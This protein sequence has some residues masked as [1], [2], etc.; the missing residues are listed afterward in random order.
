MSDGYKLQPST[1]NGKKGS[2]AAR[3]QD[4]F[5]NRGN[6]STP[7]SASCKKL[8]RFSPRVPH[9]NPQSIQ[10]LFREL[11]IKSPVPVL[12]VDGEWTGETKSVDKPFK[13][14]S[15]LSGMSLTL[16]KGFLKQGLGTRP[17]P[18]V[19]PYSQGLTSNAG[20]VLAG[21]TSDSTMLTNSTG[22]TE[23]KAIFDEVEIQGIEVF[24]CPVNRYSKISTVSR[25]LVFNHDDDSN[26]TLAS[27]LTAIY[28]YNSEIINIDDPHRMWF[29]R[30]KPEVY[31]NQWQTTA[32]FVITGGTQWF[33]DTLTIN[34]LYGTLYF[35]VHVLVR[36][37][38]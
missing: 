23:A 1:A 30:P 26:S 32:S 12:D 34:T 22:W 17:I 27:Y 35:K 18:M 24:F 15:P 8:A 16:G 2:R 10:G 29:P 25:E 33:A 11:S 21:S 5:R 9:K 6:P 4:Y 13:M 20:G 19:F 37:Q 7:N 14:P 28:Y 38:S 31:L 36:M 3:R